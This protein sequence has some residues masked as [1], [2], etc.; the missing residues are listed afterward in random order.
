VRGRFLKEWRLAQANG[1]SAV[2]FV[3]GMVAMRAVAAWRGEVVAGLSTVRELVH[4]PLGPATLVRR[5]EHAE[6]DATAR[7]LVR[8]WGAS[9]F[10]SF[11][12]I[13]GAQDGQ[14][15]LL[16]C[17]PR[18]VPITH[19]GAPVLGV[20]LCAALAAAMQG[21][22]APAPESAHHERV[23]LFPQEWRRDPSSPWLRE[24]YHD[25]PWDDP[26]LLRWLIAGW[27]NAP[28]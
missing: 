4:P 23:A 26:P 24:V 6:M 17:N 22:P 9:G 15:Y 14:A 2:R 10:L 18:P 3:P 28:R 1:V 20:D 7:A 25:V 12:F 16:E 21:R 8:R 11:D 13:I 5:I 27:A 19:L